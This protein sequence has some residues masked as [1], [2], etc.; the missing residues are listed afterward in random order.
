MP[1]EQSAAPVY[2]KELY[3]DAAGLPD[4]GQI[5]KR[6]GCGGVGFSETGEISLAFQY[7][8]PEE[9]VVSATDENGTRFGD[10]TTTLEALGLLFAILQFPEFFKNQ[11][12]VV[13]ID[14]LGV[15]WGM[16]NQKA[17]EDTV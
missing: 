2:R 10:K 5:W 15:V 1:K 11:H 3:T 14:N 13:K 16:L 17:K 6:P 7:T 12:V 9:F 4:L 8:W